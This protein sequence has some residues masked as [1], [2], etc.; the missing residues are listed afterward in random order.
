MLE[1]D[2]STGEGG[3]QILRSALAL[4]LVTGTPF[5]IE[6][7]RAGRDVPGLRPQ[8]RAAVRAA[9]RVGNAHVEGDAVGSQRLV[10]TPQGITGGHHS[11]RVG[12]AG[13][14]TLVFQT[15]LPA[16][17]KASEPSSLFFDGGTH[18]PFAPPFDFI[19]RAFLPLLARM[20]ARVS[21]ELE[22]PGFYPAGGGSF[23]ARTEPS[24]LSPIEV[25]ERGELRS[26][27]VV[28]AVS[29]LPLDIVERELDTIGRALRWDRSC[30]ERVAIPNARG[31]GN[32]I[33][34]DIACEHVTEVV[35]AIGERGIRAEEVARRAVLEVREYLDSGA[36][37]GKHLADQLVLL[38][39]L[40]GGG[41]FRTGAPTPHTTT[42]IEVL[43]KFLPVSVR[44]EQLSEKVWQLSLERR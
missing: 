25:L 18:N 23:T 17:L 38:L 39:A 29:R 26:K 40:A 22:R 21:L 6:K 43:S 28:A 24:P 32:Y 8:H 9:A 42:Q 2:G 36:P 20:G 15:V 7:I 12:T 11:F 30:F 44:A 34:I 19:E 31:P 27:H 33:A 4:S 1:L 37:V 14:A 13:S 35:T 16:L 3:G 41:S 10:F 5:S